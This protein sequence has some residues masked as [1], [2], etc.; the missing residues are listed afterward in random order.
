MTF[1][2]LRHFYASVLIRAGLSVRVVAD[3]LGHADASLTLNVY[4]HLWPDE[5][6]RTRSAVDALFQAPADQV[7]TEDPSQVLPP[8]AFPALRRSVGTPG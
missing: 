2:D 8:A 7:R 5:E 1:H 4:A 3:R 6:D